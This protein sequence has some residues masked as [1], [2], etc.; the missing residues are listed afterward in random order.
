[1]A[2]IKL[3]IFHSCEVYSSDCMEN[4][5]YLKSSSGNRPSHM[6]QNLQRKTNKKKQ[7]KNSN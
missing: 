3:S 2:E 4:S 5:V 7:Q 1:M 6:D